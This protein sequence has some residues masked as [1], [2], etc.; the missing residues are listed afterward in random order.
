MASF[1]IFCS[2]RLW[3]AF[4]SKPQIYPHL[5]IREL[6]KVHARCHPHGRHEES[7]AP[8]HPPHGHASSAASEMLIAATAPTLPLDRPSIGRNSGDPGPP[9]GNPPTG[10]P[11]NRPKPPKPQNPVGIHNELTFRELE[12][13][14]ESDLTYYGYRYYDPVTGRWPSRYPIGER[15]GVNLY[16]FVGNDGMGLWDFLGMMTIPPASP[17][18]NPTDLPQHP[19][20]SRRPDSEWGQ[21]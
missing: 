16:G 2:K 11:P 15:G 12:N 13:S 9:D 6:Q 21:S 17:P 20:P 1:A 3:H 18:F 10:S 5:N 8:S 4:L 19:F 14:R 7:I